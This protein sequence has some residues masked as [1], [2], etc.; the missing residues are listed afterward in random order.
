[1]MRH[2]YKI[3]ATLAAVAT[4]LSFGIP[5]A[6]AEP[7]VLEDELASYID[8]NGIYTV[9]G[10]MKN[11]YHLAIK[12]TLTLYIQDN[13]TLHDI[14][15]PYDTIPAG[16]ELP[17][18]IKIPDASAD[19]H[20][21]HYSLS[22]DISF[23][24]GI[25]LDVI[26]DATLVI[27]PDGHLTGQAI[28]SGD[29]ILNNPIIWAVIHG[30]NGPLDVAQNHMPLGEVVPGQIVSF[31]MYPDPVI[32]DQ[33]VYYSCFAPSS[34]S[35]YPLRS[36]RNGQ[37]YNLRYESGAWFYKPI[38]NDNGTAVAIQTTNSFPFE[39]F[40]NIEIPAVTRAETFQVLRNGEEIESIQSIDEMGMWHV[41]FDIRKQSQD[42]IT[43]TGFESGPILPAL[44]PDYVRE[45][46][47]AWAVGDADDEAILSDLTL[48]EDRSLLPKGQDGDPA[49]PGWVKMPALWWGISQITDDEFLTLITY[50]LNTGLIRL[51]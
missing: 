34:D 29:D 49:I 9:I 21:S 17:F 15:V 31:E 28:N 8:A 20:L 22:Y 2:P 5:W 13:S 37:T 4:L 25:S 23:S 44:I 48:L 1:M 19:A 3:Y 27:H 45:N 33:V 51:G 41:V 50:S 6:E 39:V 46:I 36:D 18:K 35:V 10:N 38:F 24:D 14:I 30:V 12:P 11:D 40:A 7:Y 32:S 43:I 16:G 42:V 26:Y 47:L